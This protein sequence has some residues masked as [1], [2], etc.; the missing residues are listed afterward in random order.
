MTIFD[1]PP[2]WRDALDVMRPAIPYDKKAPAVSSVVVEMNLLDLHVVPLDDLDAV[3]LHWV[4][5]DRPAPGPGSETLLEQDRLGIVEI[6][7]EM[8]DE[9]LTLRSYVAKG[10]PN[11]AG[12]VSMYKA[13]GFTITDDGDR[14]LI[15]R[16]PGWDMVGTA[17]EATGDVGEWLNKVK[18]KPMSQRWKDRLAENEC[19]CPCHSA[20]QGQPDVGHRCCE[21]TEV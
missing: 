2:V 7:A 5:S 20:R 13:L 6:G 10:R 16:V 3:E 18:G 11:A 12:L 4:I 8:N 1:T 17:E 9:G 19:G 21:V 15:E 14:S